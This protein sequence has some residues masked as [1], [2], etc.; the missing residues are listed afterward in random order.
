MTQSFVKSEKQT[1]LHIGREIMNHA[2]DKST[3]NRQFLLMG[4]TSLY[5]INLVTLHNL[6]LNTVN[7]KLHVNLRG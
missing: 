4:Y 7:N 2:H 6:V 5:E 1:N 3:Q